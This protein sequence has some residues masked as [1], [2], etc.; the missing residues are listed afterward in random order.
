M[1]IKTS[2]SLDAC[3]FLDTKMPAAHTV[4][5]RTHKFLQ[6]LLIV[7]SCNDADPHTTNKSTTSQR[8]LDLNVVVVW[9]TAALISNNRDGEVPVAVFTSQCMASGHHHDRASAKLVP[10]P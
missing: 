8:K 5:T 6:R 10:E 9:H 2:S 1:S 3:R 4:A 7:C